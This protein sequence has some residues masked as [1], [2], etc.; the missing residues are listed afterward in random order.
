MTTH[1]LMSKHNY[2]DIIKSDEFATL[3]AYNNW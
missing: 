2:R 1:S 3:L